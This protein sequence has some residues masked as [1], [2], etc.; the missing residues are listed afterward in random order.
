M[1]E[2]DPPGPRGN[3][4]PTRARG[5]TGPT[6][7]AGATGAP[8]AQ[9]VP[10]PRGPTG[11]AGPPGQ[12]PIGGFL[13]LVDSRGTLMGP[14]IGQLMV[15]INGLVV[16]VQ[17]PINH[18]GF[19]PYDTSLFTFIHTSTD[20]S[21]PRYLASDNF[22]SRLFIF[23]TTGYYAATAG[24][25]LLSYSYET[26][27]TGADITQPGH[28]VSVSTPASFP[29]GPVQTIDMNTLGLVPPF[30]LEIR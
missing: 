18:S 12:T 25:E 23:G 8:G 22:A 15:S 3:T 24:M 16:A 4:G 20:C 7:P 30:S 29:Y 11:P 14:D 17:N 26:F 27:P 10:G 19:Q 21:G 13:D 6:G 9:G 28:C 1:W 5:A 2:S